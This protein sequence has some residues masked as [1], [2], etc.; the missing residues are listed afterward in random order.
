MNTETAQ[1]WSD[2][3]D[4]GAEMDRRIAEH[5]ATE[6]EE[7]ATG[8]RHEL[9]DLEFTGGRLPGEPEFRHV[10]CLDCRKELRKERVWR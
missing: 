5:E 8:C 2:N 1:E 9:V 10:V 7:S 4:W 3:L 6:F